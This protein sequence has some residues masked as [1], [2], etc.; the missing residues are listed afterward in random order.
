MPVVLNGRWAGMEAAQWEPWAAATTCSPNAVHE[1]GDRV[2]TDSLAIQQYYSERW[3]GRPRF[4]PYGAHVGG[5]VH[6]EILAGIPVVTRFLLPRR[7]R[8]E[9]ENN[10]DLILAAFRRVVNRQAV[11]HRRRRELSQHVSSRRLHRHGDPRVRCSPGVRA[12]GTCESCI[13]GVCI[14]A[15]TRGGG[16]NPALVQ[17]LGAGV[18][19]WRS[20]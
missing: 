7:G 9:P 17:A 1:G 8:L 13:A 11:G 14:C 5:A 3:G 15:R 16:T 20:T 4:V 19:A 2:V 10:A 6:P 18:C 12:G